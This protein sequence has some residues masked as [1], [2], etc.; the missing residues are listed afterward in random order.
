MSEFNKGRRPLLRDAGDVRGPIV[1]PR[2]IENGNPSP[3]FKGPD[4]P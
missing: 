3:E 2:E 4:R 1:A